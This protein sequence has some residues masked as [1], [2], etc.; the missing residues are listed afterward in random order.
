MC[1]L[2]HAPLHVWLRDWLLCV[3]ARPLVSM[4]MTPLSFALFSPSSSDTCLFSP[5]SVLLPT[6]MMTTSWPRSLRTSSIH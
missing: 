5:K 1:Q 6:S 3:Y 4:N 2:L